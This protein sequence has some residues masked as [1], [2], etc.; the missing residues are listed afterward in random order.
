MLLDDAG[1]EI[2]ETYQGQLVKIIGEVVEIKGSYVYID[3]GTDETKIY[4]KSTVQIDKSLFK[5]GETIEI[6]GIVSKSNGSYRLL[7]RYN[8]DLLRFAEVKGEQ[9]KNIEPVNKNKKYFIAIII[10][11]G[12]LIS[13]LGYRKINFKTP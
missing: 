10:F 13:W 11:I 8:T 9:D 6:V 12:L 2:D 7:P 3:D 1:A 5:E 4:L